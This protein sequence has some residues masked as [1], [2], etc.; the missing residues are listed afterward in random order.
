MNEATRATARDLIKK[1]RA[2]IT[3]ARVDILATLLGAQRPLS[4][5]DIQELLEP[6]LDRVTVY[7]VLDWLTE[8]NLAH[9]LSGDDR[10][11]RFSAAKAPHHH[12]HFHCQQC[13]RFYCLEDVGTDL[14]MTLPKQFQADSVEITVKGVCADCKPT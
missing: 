13:G 5:L 12:A 2:R 7:R 9:K 3:P 1:T 10:V 14:P 8:E 6:S 4:H 11:W